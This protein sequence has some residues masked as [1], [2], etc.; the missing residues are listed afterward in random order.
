MIQFYLKFINFFLDKIFL[1]DI[2]VTSEDQKGILLY[3]FDHSVNYKIWIR[4]QFHY[5]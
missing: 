3:K 1:G 4:F 2:P 5:W